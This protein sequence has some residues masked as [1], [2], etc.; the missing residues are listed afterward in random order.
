VSGRRRLGL[1]A[2]VVVAA[3]AGVALVGALVARR[4]CVTPSPPTRSTTTPAAA[5]AASATA[6]AIA[7]ATPVQLPPPEQA[8]TATEVSAP[9]PGAAPAV[10]TAV[11]ASRALEA[12][13]KN[14]QMR[15]L[16]MRLQPLGLSREQQDRVLVILGTA[17]LSPAQESPT[18]QELRAAGGSRVLSEDEANRVRNERQRIDERAARSLRPALATVLTPSQMDRAGLSGNDPT[19]AARDHDPR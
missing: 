10:L 8:S 19:T 2:A 13:G 15:R 11:G 14:E 9:L 17:A 1:V 4:A 6:R 16:F 18:L 7:A 3:I 5:T 12:I